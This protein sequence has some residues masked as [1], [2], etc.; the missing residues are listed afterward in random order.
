MPSSLILVLAAVVA[1]RM[2]GRLADVV[3]A[4]LAM[5][6][7]F[8]LCLRDHRDARD[9]SACTIAPHRLDGRLWHKNSREQRLLAR[10]TRNA[11]STANFIIQYAWASARGKHLADWCRLRL[12][13]R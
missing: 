1:F 5:G 6:I 3:T 2:A 4:T 10:A 7:A 8:A 11:V 13:R 9:L 12:C